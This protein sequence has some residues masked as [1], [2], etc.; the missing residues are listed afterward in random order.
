MK[1]ANCAEESDKM[2]QCSVCK[3]SKYCS[4]ECQSQAW[5]EHKKTCSPPKPKP[6]PAK[7]DSYTLFD[8]IGRGNFTD[9]FAAE[10]KETKRSVAI[11]IAEKQKLVRLHKERDLMVEKH[12]LNKLKE[13]DEVVDL[14]DTFQDKFKLYMVMEKVEG[15]E[16]WHKA[17]VF[18]FQNKKL[19]YYYF[20]KLIKILKKVHKQQIAH[21][22]LKPENVMVNGPDIKLIDFGSAK[23]IEHKVWSKGNSSTGRKYFEHFMGTPNYMAPECIHNTFSDLRSDIYS[24][25]CFL[26]FLIV[27]FPAYIGGSEYLIFKQVTDGE[28]PL[29]YEFLFTEE[30]IKN[31]SDMME[32]DADKRPTIDE[33]IE[34]YSKYDELVYEEVA[35]KPDEFDSFFVELTDK[36]VKENEKADKETLLGYL[37]ERKDFINETYDDEKA[38]RM[39]RRL[40]LLFQQIKDYYSIEEFD[41]IKF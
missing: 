21:R 12:C 14:L 38:T 36:F 31:I 26:Y 25:G 28:K 8:I 34:R 24:L 17:K 40:K 23:D 9:I 29:F 5:P 39:K 20:N 37:N 27:G 16:L 3:V 18:G 19:A 30:D 41:F 33:L 1:C 35:D 13:E 11:K 10:D 6:E 22:D 15:K 4:K 2:K 7:I 32:H